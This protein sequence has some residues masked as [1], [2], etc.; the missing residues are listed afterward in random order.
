MTVWC[1]HRV[2]GGPKT[3]GYGSNCSIRQAL[4]AGVLSHVA[5]RAGMCMGM[6]ARQQQRDPRRRSP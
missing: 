3:A 1:H 5:K 6:A 4:A 2:A